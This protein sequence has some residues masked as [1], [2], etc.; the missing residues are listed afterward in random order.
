MSSTAWWVP[1]KLLPFF[2]LLLFSS[3]E[4]RYLLTDALGHIHSQAA[5]YNQQDCAKT[6]PI[7]ATLP[8]EFKALQGPNPALPPTSQADN[9]SLR[10]GILVGPSSSHVY[11]V[12]ST[13][14]IPRAPP[15]L[16]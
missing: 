4:A 11:R 8:L 13:E 7:A 16:L 3:T 2:V 10:Y 5:C 15:P 12:F 14:A 1:P 6:A 9:S